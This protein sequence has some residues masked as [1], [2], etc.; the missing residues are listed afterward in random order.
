MGVNSENGMTDNGDAVL[1]KNLYSRQMYVILLKQ[2]INLSIVKEIKL[3]GSMP[4][5][6]NFSNQWIS[7]RYHNLVIRQ[8]GLDNL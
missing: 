5:L 6:I 2:D 1:D 3:L 7:L 8:R 4:C